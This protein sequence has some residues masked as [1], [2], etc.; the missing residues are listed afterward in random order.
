MTKKKKIIPNPLALSTQEENFIKSIPSFTT[1]ETKKNTYKGR[2]ISMSDDF[3]KE[4][5]NFLKEN[6]TEGNRSSFIVRVVAE[7]I[8]NKIKQF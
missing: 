3:Y 2:M 1:S 4:L 7:Y 6:P 8:Q 5:N